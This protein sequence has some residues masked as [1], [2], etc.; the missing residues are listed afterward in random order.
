MCL[1][2]GE[3]AAEAVVD[4]HPAVVDGPVAAADD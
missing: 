3:R 4:D 2:S 1:I